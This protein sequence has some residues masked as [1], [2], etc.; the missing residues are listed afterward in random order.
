MRKSK[1]GLTSKVLKISPKLINSDGK[2]KYIAYCSFKYHKGIVKDESVCI[3]RK[4]KHYSRFYED[5][6]DLLLNERFKY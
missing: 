2:G 6:Y 1:D 4:C 5:K 3:S